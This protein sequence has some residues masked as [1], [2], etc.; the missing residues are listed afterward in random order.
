MQRGVAE[1]G[2]R[3]RER[4]RETETDRQRQRQTETK[5]DREREGGAKAGERGLIYDS[6]I[7]C[8]FE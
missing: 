2:E 6:I 3:K 7:A 5:R 1:R 8:L 4:E